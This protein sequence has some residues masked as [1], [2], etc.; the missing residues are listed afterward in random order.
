MN[1]SATKEL[2][3]C[4]YT[5]LTGNYE[6]LGAASMA[7]ESSWDFICLTDNPDMRSSGWQVRP[8]ASPFAHDPGRNSR[9]PKACP[10]RYFSDYDISLYIDN[11][12][13]LTRTP[14][15]I[16]AEAFGEGDWE[17]GA[18]QHSF[19]STVRDEFN[20]VLQMNLDDPSRIIEQYNCYKRYAPEVLDLPPFWGGFILRKHMVANVAEA[21]EYWLAHILRHSRRDQLSL[22]Y[23]L[24]NCSVRVRT[25]EM[26]NRASAFH[27]WNNKH[28]SRNRHLRRGGWKAMMPPW[29]VSYYALTRAVGR[30]FKIRLK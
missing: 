28:E 13:Q 17:W 11:S 15:A 30:T 5:V 10:H 21:G 4:V 27:T 14:E 20:R 12:V 23:A 3:G 25:I 19:R 22:P 16:V 26:D 2:R 29:I 24:R 6:A 18:V 1:P 7:E 9:I 8:F